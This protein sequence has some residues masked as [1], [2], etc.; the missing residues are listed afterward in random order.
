LFYR[1]KM[2]DKDG[3]FT[4]SNTIRLKLNGPLNNSIITIAPNP[5]ANSLSIKLQASGNQNMQLQLLDINGKLLKHKQYNLIQGI[6]QLYF[7]AG[8]LPKGVYLL[9]LITMQGVITEKVIKQ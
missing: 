7:P 6:N 9:K 5:F 4:Y 1:L 2:V 3:R 8:D